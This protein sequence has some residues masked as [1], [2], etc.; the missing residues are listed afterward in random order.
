MLRGQEVQE[1][2]GLTR[3]CLTGGAGAEID[4]A[5]VA[6]TVPVGAEIDGAS[7]VAAVP[8]GAETDRGSKASQCL[9]KVGN[10]NKRG[11]PHW[12]LVLEGPALTFAI[13]GPPALTPFAL[14][15]PF[16]SAQQYGKMK[17]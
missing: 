10:T 1:E 2:C 7:V 8:A 3:G 14:A 5:S 15:H 4:G 16:R 17:G 13:P 9:W 12:G 6:S 11:Y